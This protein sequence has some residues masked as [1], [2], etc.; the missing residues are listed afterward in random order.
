MNI[1]SDHLDMSPAIAPKSGPIHSV[2][3]NGSNASE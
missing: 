1:T 2:Y 3:L